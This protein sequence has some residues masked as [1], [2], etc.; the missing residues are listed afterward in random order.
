MTLQIS[1]ELS[2]YKSNDEKI[3]NVTLGFDNQLNKNN[4]NLI[5]D[6]LDDS[7]YITAFLRIVLPISYQVIFIF[8]FIMD[9]NKSK[10]LFYF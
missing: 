5:Y 2:N 3:L 10:F 1:S 4:I 7:A 6:N 8:D 9:E